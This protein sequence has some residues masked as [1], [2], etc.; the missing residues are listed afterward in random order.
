V[1]AGSLKMSCQRAIGA[2]LFGC[3]SAF[4]AGADSEWAGSLVLTSDY[5]FRGVSQTEGDAAIQADLHWLHRNWIAGAW[6]STVDT[7]PGPGPTLEL[8][9]YAG[10][11]WQLAEAWE[12][13]VI[14]VH[15]DYPDHSHWDYDELLTSLAFR[16]TFTATVAWSPNTSGFSERGVVQDRSAFTYELTA[17]YPW[18]TA[19]LVSA[20]VGYY[21]LHELFGNGYTFWSAGVS[22]SAAPFQ[23]TLARY[24][25]S[26]EATQLFGE[27]SAD[28]RWSLDLQWRF[29]S[30][31]P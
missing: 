20:G 16:D 12:T 28:D 4:A 6:G 25:T 21:D 27:E 5:V 17:H 8:N 24:G 22:Y 14:A 18:R 9:A 23:I 3:L 1:Q 19:W 15:Y 11:R 26:G 30:G 29:R 31:A 2:A 10:H 7:N 13:K